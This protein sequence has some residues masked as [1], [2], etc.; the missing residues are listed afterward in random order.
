M[1]APWYLAGSL[2]P[3]KNPLSL[4]RYPGALVW[5]HLN[6][7]TVG[8]IAVTDGGIKRLK[9]WSWLR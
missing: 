8:R 7:D 5:K 6:A 2:A 1:L 3:A 9:A 4:D